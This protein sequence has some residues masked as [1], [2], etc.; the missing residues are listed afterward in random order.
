MKALVLLADDLGAFF[1]SNDAPAVAALALS[2]GN[3]KTGGVLELDTETAEG[4]AEE[5]FD[6]TNNPGRQE[7]R[8]RLYGRK[9]SLS[10]GDI[11]VVG[12]QYFLCDS[13]GWTVL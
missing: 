6:L 1:F 5:V 3:Y 11:V 9:R 10:V 2:K 4:A 13:F 8:E 7:E 12:D